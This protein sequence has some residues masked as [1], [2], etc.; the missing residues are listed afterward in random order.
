MA[1]S[2]KERV[3]EKRKNIREMKH[4]QGKKTHKA[5]VEEDIWFSLT[6]LDFTFTLLTDL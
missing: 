4:R 2:V 3:A 5:E 1:E 6:A